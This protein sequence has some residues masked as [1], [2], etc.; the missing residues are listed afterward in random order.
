MPAE[1]LIAIKYSGTEPEKLTV[2]NGG[3]VSS[4]RMLGVNEDPFCLACS[5]DGKSARLSSCGFE[6][7]VNDERS[8]GEGVLGIEATRNNMS[9]TMEYRISLALLGTEKEVHAC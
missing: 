7:A 5:G 8:L 2:A 1:A 4:K 9:Y 6:L 3:E